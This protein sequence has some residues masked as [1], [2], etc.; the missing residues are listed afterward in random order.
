MSPAFS[1]V[2][3]NESFFNGQK[4]V[5]SKILIFNQASNCNKNSLI[6]ISLNSKNFVGCWREEF[7]IGPKEFYNISN[8][9]SSLPLAVVV[10]GLSTPSLSPPA[11]SVY[12][13]VK[14]GG[15]DSRISKS[16]AAW[17]RMSLADNARHRPSKLSSEG[18]K[19]HWKHN[20]V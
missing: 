9:S 12:S 6:T 4:T 16:G 2:K 8:S 7:H 3:W 11:P 17:P 19:K 15:A 1:V 20:R 13:S 10:V 5:K 14:K 18:Q